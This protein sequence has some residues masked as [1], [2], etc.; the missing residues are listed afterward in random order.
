MCTSQSLT[1]PAFRRRAVMTALMSARH[2][3]VKALADLWATRQQHA[4][5]RRQIL[6]VGCHKVYDRLPAAALIVRFI[7]RIQQDKHTPRAC[8]ASITAAAQLC[9]RCQRS[10]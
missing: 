6:K 8:A 10:G 3:S 5:P 7:K 1:Y 9:C 4:D 2:P